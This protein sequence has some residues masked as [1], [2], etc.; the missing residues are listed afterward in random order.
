MLIWAILSPLS[1]YNYSREGI[2]GW[3]IFL[4]VKFQLRTRGNVLMRSRMV[5][6]FYF[7]PRE[8][9]PG[10]DPATGCQQF[11]LLLHTPQS[12]LS[13]VTTLLRA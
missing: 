3:I 9:L 8:I 5:R 12:L 13:N 10:I 11:S 7:L 6:G 4:S 2:D 1:C